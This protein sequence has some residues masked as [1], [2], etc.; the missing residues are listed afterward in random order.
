LN[1]KSTEIKERIL[2]LRQEMKENGI[3]GYYISGTDPHLS[4]Y[5][6]KR[7]QTRAYISGFT[8]SAGFVVVTQKEVALW[9]DSR[10]FIQAAIQLESTG[11]QLMKMRIEET[12]E[13]Y[14]WLSSVSPEGSIIGIDT[15]SIS[16]LQYRNFNNSLKKE[17][18]SLKDTGDLLNKIWINRPPLPQDPVFEH[19]LKYAGESRLKKIDRIRKKMQEKKIDATIISALDDLA[20][21]FNLRGNDVECNPVFM[22]YSII[23][24][25][26]V[27]LY[28]NSDKVPY[29]IRENLKNDKIGIE[30]YERIFEGLKQIQGKIM[31]DPERTN[32][33]L[34]NCI[35]ENNEIIEE[36]SIP[37]MLKAI[38]SDF[39]LKN[40]RK[41]LKK[42]GVAMID[43]LFWLYTNV[44]KKEFTDYDVALKLDYFRSLQKGYKGMS[45]WPVVGYKD[46]GA[47]V[48]L[49]VT[50]KFQHK[51]K[52]EGMLLFDSGG[53]YISGTTDITRTVTL[54]KPTAQQKKD[55]TL[56]LKGTIG[57]ANAKFPSG[58]KG[59]N[60]D[61]LARKALWDNGMNY[62]HGTSH[63]IGY[64]LNVHEGPMDIR[65]E[66]N[67]YD[68]RPGMVL[69][70]EPGFYREGHYG[71]RIENMLVC[72]EIEKTDYGQFY[73]FETLTLC[74]IDKN[75]IDTKLI[76]T[77]ERKWID[78][79]HQRCFDELSPILK[80]DEE[81]DFLKK[82]TKK[83]I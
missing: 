57:L 33:A 43:F 83:L 68:L 34:L 25:K 32:Q 76:T 5:L 19:E 12:P 64:F 7:W 45:F 6:P 53:Q 75:L 13:P 35:P 71:I 47:I 74:P 70:D 21:T 24:N 79:Y 1:I 72:T 54:N 26:K 42:D 62:G 28:I 22:G 18:L 14:K 44:G 69:S 63:G 15:E 48:H 30:P 38:K 8:G 40:I 80:N 29:K 56:V 78:D 55:F 46:L 73:G 82:L 11:I 39:E 41:T 17:K 60:I 61:L 49:N 59:S 67:N 2:L 36:L 37:D 58:T 31:I 77:E 51:I 10:Y 16:I 65:Q 81:K 4:E 23:T 9:T 66:Y 50:K 27:S 3:Y 52:K 20:W